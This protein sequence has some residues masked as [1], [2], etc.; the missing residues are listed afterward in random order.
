LPKLLGKLWA[1][2]SETLGPPKKKPREIIYTALCKIYIFAEILILPSEIL[3]SADMNYF[4]VGILNFV[5]LPNVI[6]PIAAYVKEMIS[7]VMKFS[8]EMPK[9]WFFINIDETFRRKFRQ[10][11]S[12]FRAKT[13]AKLLREF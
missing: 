1:I 5:Q 3:S 2:F 10:K 13:F 9:F 7:F 6:R 8:S 11:Y 12:K 4:N